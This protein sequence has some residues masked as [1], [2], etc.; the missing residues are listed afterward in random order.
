[1]QEGMVICKNNIGAMNKLSIDMENGEIELD[2]KKL[3]FVR[4]IKIEIND[5]DWARV[6][7]DM[8]VSLEKVLI[9]MEGQLSA[10]DG[11]DREEILHGQ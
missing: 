9:V 5:T 2:G 4:G 1:M 6:C 11:K 10:L 3:Q 7:I 8:D